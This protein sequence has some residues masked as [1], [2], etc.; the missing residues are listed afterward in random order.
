MLFLGYYSNIQTSMAAGVAYAKW[1]LLEA[2]DP[3]KQFG[4]II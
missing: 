2:V 1:F 4:N 3:F